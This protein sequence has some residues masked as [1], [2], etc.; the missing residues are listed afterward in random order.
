MMKL[1]TIGVEYIY[2][3]D[4]KRRYKISFYSGVIDFQNINGIMPKF[5]NYCRS[6][7]QQLLER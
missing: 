4:P 3:A 7:K 6:T 2:A 5:S 1:C